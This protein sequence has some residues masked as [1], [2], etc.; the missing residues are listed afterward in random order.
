MANSFALGSRVKDIMKIFIIF[1][2]GELRASSL[3]YYSYFS[4]YLLRNLKNSSVCLICKKKESLDLFDDVD[5]CLMAAPQILTLEPHNLTAELCTEKSCY[6]FESKPL[7]AVSLPLENKGIGEVKFL[8][9]PNCNTKAQTSNSTI[10]LLC[11][12]HFKLSSIVERKVI[13]NFNLTSICIICKPD[14]HLNKEL[15]IT[16]CLP[17]FTPVPKHELYK[18]TYMKFPECDKE[19]QSKCEIGIPKKIHDGIYC[20][21]KLG[22][23]PNSSF[24]RFDYILCEKENN[25]PTQV[26]IFFGQVVNPHKIHRL[27]VPNSAL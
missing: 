3:V 8:S 13:G 18:F 9:G 21:S 11:P 5:I 4:E 19:D 27:S 15:L 2:T 16:M 10:D 1:S 7:C 26:K 12:Q 20:G 6:E 24:V 22:T 25:N 23:E 14:Q 17:A